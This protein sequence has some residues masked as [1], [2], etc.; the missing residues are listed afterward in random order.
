MT[1]ISQLP[2]ITRIDLKDFPN[3]DGIRVS[4]YADGWKA[5]DRPIDVSTQ[6]KLTFE[7]MVTWLKDNGWDVV[8]WP[9]S[10]ILGVPR[11]A[12][13]FLGER[14]SVRTNWELKKYRDQLKIKRDRYFQ[15]PESFGPD[16]DQ[17]SGMLNCLDLAFVL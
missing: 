8:E 10:P 17:L 5:T 2:K 3:E 6:T 13:A 11:G 15:T 4:K 14:R 12:R 9:A 7:E 1:S 16:L